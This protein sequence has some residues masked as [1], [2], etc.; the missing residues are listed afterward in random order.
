MSCVEALWFFSC[1]FLN[2]AILF[3]F[4]SYNM[5]LL[6]IWSFKNW[7]KILFTNCYCLYKSKSLKCEVKPRFCTDQ[8]HVRFHR[9]KNKICK[10]ICQSSRAIT[11]QNKYHKHDWIRQGDFSSFRDSVCDLVMTFLLYYLPPTPIKAS[12]RLPSMPKWR[13]TK[14]PFWRQYISR[15]GLVYYDSDLT[16]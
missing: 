15:L 2:L 4:I 9:K 11:A 13:M 16:H 1:W 5:E 8:M 3:I 10:T 6:L 14:M 7:C 12:P